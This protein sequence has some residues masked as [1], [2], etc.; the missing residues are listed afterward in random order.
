MFGTWW[1]P[2][3]PDRKVAGEVMLTEQGAWRLRVHGSLFE[4][5]ELASLPQDTY[6]EIPVIE[7]R[8]ADN[9]KVSLMKCWYRVSPWDSM[10][11]LPD[12]TVVPEDWIFHS[13]AVGNVCVRP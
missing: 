13:Y 3:S 1:L 7:G 6:Y 11:A 12:A 10:A 4:P 8:N 2:T 9:Q 5:S